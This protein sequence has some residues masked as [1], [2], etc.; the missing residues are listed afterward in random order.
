[1]TNKEIEIFYPKIQ[2]DWRNWLQKKS[3]L[4]RCRLV[5]DVQ[6]ENKYW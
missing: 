4:K 1:M 2:Q 3:C 5:D 6:T